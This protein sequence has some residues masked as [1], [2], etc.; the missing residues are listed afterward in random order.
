M[1]ETILSTKSLD[2]SIRII[3]LSK[4]LQEKKEF[5][6]SKQIVRS[7]T[8]I[9]ANIREAK[10]AQSDLDFIHK[11]SIALKE[12]NET[13]YWLEL[14]YRT[15]YISKQHYLEMRNDCEELLRI[16]HSTVV[17]CKKKLN[18]QNK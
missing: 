9:G 18:N 13:L 17:T 8:S 7:G 6:M 15:D 14:L 11:M 1:A 5:I 16:L 3:N 4:Y 12:S 10:F 2:F